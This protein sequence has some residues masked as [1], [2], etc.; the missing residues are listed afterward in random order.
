MRSDGSIGQYS[1]GI[2]RKK[3]PL[4]RETKFSSRTLFPVKYLCIRPLILS[5]FHFTRNISRIFFLEFRTYY[6]LTAHR[7]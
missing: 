1:C 2:E 5:E 7:L 4:E 6:D 3:W